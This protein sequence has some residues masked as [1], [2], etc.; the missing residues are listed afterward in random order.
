MGLLG[1]V[2]QGTRAGYGMLTD[3]YDIVDDALEKG[4]KSMFLSLIDPI[5]ISDIPEVI[6]SAAE[7]ISSASEGFNS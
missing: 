7:D 4:K 1:F 6:S 3:N 5:G 2:Y